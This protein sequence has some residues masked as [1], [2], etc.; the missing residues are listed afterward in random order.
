[1]NLLLAEA[2]E[3]SAKG[4]LWLDDRRAE[5]LQKV[6]KVEVGQSI[7]VG[8][9]GGRQGIAEVLGVESGSVQLAVPPELVHPVD[10]LETEDPPPTLPPALDV[11]LALPRPQALHRV[12]QS[13]ATMGVRR[14]DLVRSWRVEKSFFHSPSL[15]EA[16]IRKHLWLG[17]EQG[18][19]TRLPEV[20]IHPVLRP[21]LEHLKAEDTAQTLRLLAHPEASRALQDV[22]GDRVRGDG[23]WGDGVRC[24]SVRGDRV[25]RSSAGR[26]QVAI[27]PEGGWID[28][29]VESLEGLGFHGVRLGPWI[30]KVE[31]AL[32]A[33]LAQL[34]L[35]WRTTAATGC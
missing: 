23:V 20:H 24:N 16:S 7:K 17:A 27:G 5:H 4:E 29:E 22:W 32:T 35:L 1:M 28:R 30:L 3:L 11:I 18:M 21:F 13:A 12:L 9:L 19:V 26:L 8:V 25:Q 14:L 6:L 2:S 10:C 34:D 31:N 33:M 15:G